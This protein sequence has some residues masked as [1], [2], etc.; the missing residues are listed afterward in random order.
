MFISCRQQEGWECVYVC[1]F[2]LAVY[3]AIYLEELTATE[4][5]EKIAQLFNISPRQINQIFK[6]GPTGI[7]VLVSDEVR[8]W[9]P[10]LHR[11]HRQ[12]D[13]T[14]SSQTLV[15]SFSSFP[16][17]FKHKT[18]FLTDDSELPGWSVF[19]TG[20]NER[21][22]T[23][24]YSFLCISRR[25]LSCQ[26]IFITPSISVF[27]CPDDTND[28]YHIILKWM[29]SRRKASL[30]LSA[31]LELHAPRCSW[32]MWKCR[33]KPSK[34]WREEYVSEALVPLL[35]IPYCL[36]FE[37]VTVAAAK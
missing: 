6:Q 4:L 9:P 36:T 31:P 5:T 1:V 30:F 11:S 2:V 35:T 18:L 13:I 17:C 8:P 14:E 21:Y 24:I 37:G 33:E 15:S 27:P 22:L 26:R 19:C 16:V 12:T 20:H 3:H 23:V 28:G 29:Q 25:A 7:H 32:N 34:G 10:F